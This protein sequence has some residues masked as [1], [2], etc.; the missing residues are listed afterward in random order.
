MTSWCRAHDHF[1]SS[2]ISL[3]GNLILRLLLK[4]LKAY[5]AAL[6]GM[7]EEER[8]DRDGAKNAMKGLKYAITALEDN[9]SRY[10]ASARQEAEEAYQKAEE[11]ARSR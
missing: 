8:I 2:I 9:I 5:Y 11:F 6:P 7:V 10:R 3:P 4:W 1:S